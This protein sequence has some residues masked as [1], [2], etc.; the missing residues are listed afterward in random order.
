MNAP[1]HEQ[2]LAFD[3]AGE[4]L[5]GIVT[6]PSRA[7]ALGVVVIVG[8]PQ[9]RAGS[10]R[11]F[12]QLAR[13]LAGAGFPVLRFDARGMGDSGGEPP[14]FEALQ[15]DIDA[16]I[17]ALQGAVPGLQRVVLWGLC[18]AA[19]AA[20]LYLKARGGDTRVAG[21]CALNPWVRSAT[22]EAQ[23]RVRHYYFQ[24]LREPAFWRKLAT[25]GVSA[26]ALRGLAGNLRKALGRGVTGQAD[27]QQ[28]YQH[29]MAAA[30]Q[31]FQGR[32]LL[33]LSGR[34]LTAREFEL[35]R[36]ADTRWTQSL[37]ARSCR[38]ER[39]PEADHT[40]SDA[41]SR[42]RLEAL[43]TEWLHEVLGT[44]GAAS[45]TGAAA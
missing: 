35:V 6:R 29:R 45:A 24:R 14:S 15:P 40:F 5:A 38:L 28:P 12:V 13:A 18:D 31:A 7:H 42:Q 3:A 21:L 1:W 17:G 27:A 4:R 33:V 39:L 30:W 19:S 22:T 41:A 26:G 25:G 44:T 8:G 11:Q 9:Y 32:L 10:H 37:Q 36:D 43:C 20:L 23:A 2:V 16:A 34:D